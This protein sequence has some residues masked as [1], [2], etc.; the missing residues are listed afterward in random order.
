MDRISINLLPLDL[1][2]NKKNL[3]QKRLINTISIGILTSL[4]IVSGVLVVLSIL[5][6]NQ[7]NSEKNQLTN[8]E[9]TV[10]SLKEKEAA[11][12]ILKKRI[13]DISQIRNQKYPQADSFKLTTS[14][15]PENVSIQSFN[16]EKANMVTV[17][18]LSN[19]AASL[20]KFFDNLTDPK[21]NEGKITK[22]V[23]TNLNR[24]SS[25][26]LGFDLEINTKTE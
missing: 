23:I 15:L 16:S 6:N 2:E 17:Q 8:L 12:I 20:Q 3:K 22:T 11:V 26:Q 5:Q 10:S 24:G 14:L 19:D 4:V 21:I 13:S 1:K 25:P 7:L 9:N 18:G